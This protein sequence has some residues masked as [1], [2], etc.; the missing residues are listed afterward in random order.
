[1]NTKTK[2][3]R[4]YP[5]EEEFIQT[6][7]D[8][9]EDSVFKQLPPDDVSEFAELMQ[10]VGKEFIKRYPEVKSKLISL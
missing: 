9:I 3:K 2:I 7:C 10:K 6:L 4:E 8:T 5:S 1:M